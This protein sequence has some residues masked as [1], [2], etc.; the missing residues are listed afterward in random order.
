MDLSEKRLADHP[1]LKGLS[2]D[3]L[4]ILEDCSMRRVFEAGEVIFREGDLANRFYLILSGSVVLESAREG[5]SP[6]EIQTIGPGDVLGWSWLFPPYGWRYDARALE[7]TEALFL[8]GTR[9]R[10]K[11]EEQPALGYELIK[12][13]S[14]VIIQ[15]LQATR[16]EL[17]RVI[18][19]SETGKP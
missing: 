6:I 17:V 11:C 16:K 8:Y 5:A 9:I 4:R 14:M 15:R 1:F 2:E 12:R 10:A 7:R 3:H 18:T 19:K 13:M